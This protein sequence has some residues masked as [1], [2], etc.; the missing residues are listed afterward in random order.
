MGIKKFNDT[1]DNWLN[2]L[3]SVSINRLSEKPYGTGWSIGQLYRH[4]IEESNWYNS[5]IEISLTDDTNSTIPT[6]EDARI[7]LERGSFENKSFQG[8]P[9]I[10]ENIEQP[11]SIA[12]IKFDLEFLKTYTNKLWDRMNNTSSYG[13]SE[14]PGIGYLN[15]FEWLQYS[16]MHMRHHL[17]Q[18]KRIELY[19]DQNNIVEKK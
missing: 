13:K 5:Q 7:L 3:D 14:H 15:C 10:H 9:L 6:T 4:I 16:E 12:E 8:D 11:S 2:E 17:E 1:I 19:L 18:R